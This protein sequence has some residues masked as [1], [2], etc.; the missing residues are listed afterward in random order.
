MSAGPTPLYSNLLRSSIRVQQDVPVLQV[1]CLGPCLEMLLEGITALDGR[2][3]RFVDRFLG[4]I[5]HSCDFLMLYS[6]EIR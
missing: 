1:L 4:L 2:D 6:V 5:C 3:G